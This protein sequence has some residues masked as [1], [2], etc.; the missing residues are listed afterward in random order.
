M[1]GG[2]GGTGVQ[3]LQSRIRLLRALGGFQKMLTHFFPFSRSIRI[4][5]GIMKI[6]GSPSI[7]FSML[8]K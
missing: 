8:L 1:E 7:E 6:A 5:G 4:R 2:G 3:S